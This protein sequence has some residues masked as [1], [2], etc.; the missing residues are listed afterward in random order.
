MSHIY[1]NR[2]AT[3]IAFFYELLIVTYEI[4]LYLV[5]MFRNPPISDTNRLYPTPVTEIVVERLI[6][7]NILRN[8][9]PITLI[10]NSRDSAFRTIMLFHNLTV[11]YVI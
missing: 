11:R 4:R 9:R 8:I 5:P 2:F 7:V 3:S 6:K 10:L 1:S